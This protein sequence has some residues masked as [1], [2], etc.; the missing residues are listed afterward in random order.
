[1]AS[2]AILN[3][4]ENGMLNHSKPRMVNMYTSTKLDANIFISDPYNSRKPWAI[5]G[6]R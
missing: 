4:T 6:P 3:F 1:M 2:A 5:L